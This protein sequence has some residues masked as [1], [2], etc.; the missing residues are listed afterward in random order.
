MS[1]NLLQLFLIGFAYLLFLFGAAYITDRG[2]LPE[3]LVRHPAVYV[4]SLGVYA[5]VWT[6]YGAIGLAH[7]YG[8][9]F[10][11]SYLGASATF[12]L[13][14]VL[15]FPLLRI[16][17]S[18]Q[19]SSVADLFAFRFRSQR[20]GTLVTLVM[21][22]GSLPL[23]AIQIQAVTDSIHLLNDQLPART[24]ALGFCLLV[25]VFAILFGARHASI[26]QKHEG[27]VVAM[28][29]ES[30]IKVLALTI[31]GLYC[32][33]VV[34]DGNADLEQWLRTNSDRL[35]R[36]YT[37]VDSDAWRTLL[38]AFFSA[39]MVMPHMFHML[40]T[41]NLNP[42]ALAKASWGVPLLLLI[43][44]FWIPPILWAGLKLELAGNPEYFSLNLGLEQESALLTVLAFIG[45]LSAASGIV[46]VSTI[47][48]SGMAINH[49]LLPFY[50]NR[51]SNQ[52]YRRLVWARRALIVLVTLLAY[53]FYSALS[54]PNALH[55]LGLV[56][57]IAFMQFLP[58]LLATLFWPGGSRLGFLLGLLAGMSIWLTSMLAPLFVGGETS[59][60]GASVWHQT[61]LYSLAANIGTFLLV[62][63]LRKPDPEELHAA[64]S[65]ALN[66]LHRPQGRQ[67]PLTSVQALVDQLSPRLGSQAAWREVHQALNELGLEV[68]ETR[69]QALNQLRDRLEV[70]LSALLGPVEAIDLLS[71]GDQQTLAPYRHRDIHLLEEHL[72]SYQSRLTGLAAELDE[73]RRYHRQTLAR[74]PVGVCSLGAAGDVM[75]WNSEMERI[76]GIATE[77]AVGLPLVRL[78]SPWG[79]LLDDFSHQEHTHLHNQKLQRDAHPLWFSL[80]K[81]SLDESRRDSGQVLLVEDE[82]ETRLLADELVHSERLASI[83]RLAA[84]VAH[85]VGNPVTGIACL[86]QNLRYESDAEAIQESADQI[87]QQTGRIDRIIKSLMNFA[88]AGTHNRSLSH[89][90]FAI[91]DCVKDAIAL[92]SLDARGKQLLYA[93]RCAPEHLVNGD[94]QRLLQVFVNLLNNAA[95][96]SAPGQTLTIDSR[97]DGRQQ[98]LKV[99]VEDQGSGIPAEVQD[100]LFEPFFTTKEPGKGTGLGL[101]LV[102]SIVE[103]HYGSVSIESPVDKAENKG[104]RVTLTLPAH[105]PDRSP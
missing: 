83:G 84:G 61:A 79:E 12:L 88:H 89:D 11:A 26:R 25:A 8:Y 28:A 53:L 98:S 9:S 65:C 100:R 4:L 101:S 73:L 3:R 103:E 62:S 59:S 99:S 71:P 77:Q 48:L 70:N 13:A 92:V 74:L 57:F 41:E 90:T 60:L 87:L 104:T 75:M 66:A 35:T 67:L 32:L 72:E 16:T 80:H 95:D 55:Q 54:H 43:M 34:F 17:R 86:A 27:L 42:K 38:L 52:L 69:S 23:I 36:L 30:L 39:A 78:P 76:T 96:A 40:F 10:L 102:Y 20:A 37:P 45:G 47:A 81:A 6:F 82:T 46:I 5:S 44:A 64:S 22:L 51:G 31:I 93:N 94:A 7:N 97:M 2:W 1:F 50:S 14:P 33:F 105:Q 18:Y 19:L 68:N 63:Y 56:A 21:L 15:L 91:R 85:E 49:L 58:G 24:T 29:V